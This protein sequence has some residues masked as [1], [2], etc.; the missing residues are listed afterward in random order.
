MKQKK[1]FCKRLLTL[2]LSLAMIFTSV[3]ISPITAQ[4]MQLPTDVELQAQADEGTVS[5]NQPSEGTVP[6]DP[7]DLQVTYWETEDENKGK[8]KVTWSS[9]QGS[10][11]VPE[12][13]IV[14]VDDEEVAR[15]A[16]SESA[17]V[18]IENKY[19]AGEHT[20]KLT[21]ANSAGES[22]GI[23]QTFTL[24]EEQAGVKN[25]L[26]TEEQRQALQSLY[27]PGRHM[28]MP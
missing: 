27:D 17:E 3:N 10:A 12:N 2:V 5:D 23:T 15:V 9:E 8:I 6:A 4:A 19:T 16:V 28:Q 26:A 18:F 11:G 1:L 20:V 25:D 14:Y 21:A 7:A 24:S 22:A 13:W